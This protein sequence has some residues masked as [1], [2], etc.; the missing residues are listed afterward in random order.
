VPDRRPP[1]LTADERATLLALL[2][3]QRESFVRKVSGIDD[4]TAARVLVPSGTSLLWLTRHLARAEVLW[5]L[6]RFAGL[7]VP[8]PDDARPGDRIGDAIA[9]YRAGWAPVDRILLAADLDAERP[10]EPRDA[11]VNLRWILA[12]LLEETARHAGHADIIRELLDG[13]TGR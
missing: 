2:N 6:R 3:Y 12:H 8:L 11:A 9:D 10:P 4:A 1:R 5:V 7:D 13:S